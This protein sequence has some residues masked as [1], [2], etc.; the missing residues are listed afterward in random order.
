MEGTMTPEQRKVFE[1]VA[2]A[3]AAAADILLF[4]DQIIATVRALTDANNRY[5]I[6]VAAFSRLGKG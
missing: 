3:G 2:V 1:A 4:H 6:A 5:A